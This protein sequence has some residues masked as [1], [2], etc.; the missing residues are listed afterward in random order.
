MEPIVHD[1]PRSNLHAKLID[2]INKANIQRNDVFS[3]VERAIGLL[4]I[5][6]IIYNHEETKRRSNK[7]SNKKQLPE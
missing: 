6:N 2:I 4:N 3:T 5:D 1:T 7:N